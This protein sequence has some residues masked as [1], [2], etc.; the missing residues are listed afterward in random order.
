MP[1]FHKG[2]ETVLFIH[3]PKTGG[4]S[5]ERHLDTLAWRETFSVRGLTAGQ[6][7]YAKASPQHFHADLLER[8]FD[9]SAFS[10]VVA[11]VR[12]PFN[13]L[14][15]EYYW[16]FRNTATPPQPAV[17][18]DD[19]FNQFQNN[20]FLFDNHIRPQATFFPKDLDVKTFKLED[21]GIGK[22]LTYITGRDTIPAQSF[23]ERF[24]P[25][26][27]RKNYEKRSKYLPEVEAAFKEH[28]TKIV[29]FYQND[30]VKFNYPL[31]GS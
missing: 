24:K 4:S 7:R 12:D 2:D 17:W 13:R 15:S 14:K 26:S 18:I 20:P 1:V 25:L 6:I 3:I 30:Y 11:L 19:V 16:Q 21:N 5:L 8:V 23:K 28:R 27:R 31:E 10:K 9:L 22:A 29:D